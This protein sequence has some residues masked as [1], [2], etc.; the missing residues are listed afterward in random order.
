MKLVEKI[1][2][3]TEKYSFAVLFIL[4]TI[5]ICAMNPNL[6][7]LQ[8]VC[9]IKISAAY[10][11]NVLHGQEIWFVRAIVND[12]EVPINT[13]KIGQ[14][15]NWKYADD[16]DDWIFYPQQG[17][18]NNIL[19][20]ELKS[21]CDIEL[22]FLKNSWAGSVK[23]STPNESTVIDLY[24][25]TNSS[26]KYLVDKDGFTY[27]YWEKVIEWI[28]L[29]ILVSILVLLIELVLRKV[30]L[31][32]KVIAVC[33]IL[34]FNVLKEYDLINGLMIA[35]LTSSLLYIIYASNHISQGKS[36]K[37]G[38]AF[39]KLILHIYCVFALIANRIFMTEALMTIGIKEIG[40]FIIVTLAL[41]P[42]G[43]ILIRI[44]DKFQA[45]KEN[46]EVT[47]KQIRKIGIVCFL[48]NFFIL[49]LM[50]LGFYPATIPVD[51]VSHWTQAV[52]YSGWG[53]QDN[54]SAAFT[55]LLRICYKI[56]RSPY[57][58]IL[59]MLFL[60]SFVFARILAF[61]YKKG[62]S[63]CVVYVAAAIIAILPN[64]YT[65]LLTIKTNSLYAI[66]CIWVTYLLIKLIDNPERVSKNAGFI[67]E[68][69]I[70]LAC[71][72]VCR[73]N[74]FLAVYGTCAI[75]ILMCIVY[76]KQKKKLNIYFIIPV[77]VALVL[78]KVITGPIYT[79]FDVIRN[80]PQA[81]NVAYPLI[82]PLAVAYNNNIELS[83]DT[84]EY[85]NRIRPLESWSNH[86]PYH[87]DTFTWSEPLPQYKEIKGPEKF[88]YY[89]KMLFSRPD[90]VIKDRLDG[91]ESLWNVFASKGQKA[92]NARFFYGINTNMPKKLVISNGWNWNITTVEGNKVYFNE[93]AFTTIPYALCKLC[94]VN[95]T[96]DAFVWRTGFSI[97]LVLYAIYF[98]CMIGKKEKV[99]AVVPMIGTL[100]TLALAISWQ[101][102]QYFWVV[103]ITNWVLVFYLILPVDGRAAQD[104]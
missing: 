90:I 37:K 38:G 83:E 3:I 100:I 70:V 21:P 101:L 71:L 12:E 50:T 16:T 75:L 102:Y 2:W 58:F 34:S 104:E 30:S 64:N 40:N 67:A 15:L 20:L 13:L 14:N 61:F 72:Y 89:F 42:L 88:K 6:L 9:P 65:T 43:T 93:T 24:S 49:I 46:R 28:G 51:G 78:I 56:W 39:V 31:K 33:G 91:I 79:H 82:S 60:F 99:L 1:R 23:I 69:S 92:Y 8:K 4:T 29:L 10:D 98:T 18:T 85:M 48:I 84:L 95:I 53:I 11:E 7:R 57:G 32:D 96:L 22:V 81:S 41:L 54:T 66:L 5:F 35:L 77:A 45:H 86:N 26:V 19:V 47:T 103:H 25:E 52:S 87:G 27:A 62:V 97:V 59:L 80:T 94:A 55:I 63:S 73:H 68:M 44:F 74:S 76:I 17:E 36:T